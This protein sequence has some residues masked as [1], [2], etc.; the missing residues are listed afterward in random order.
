MN[1]QGEQRDQPAPPLQQ[2]QPP[3][4][5]PRGIFQPTFTRFLKKEPDPPEQ[6]VMPMAAKVRRVAAALRR[7][8]RMAALSECSARALSRSWFCLRM[9]GLCGR[10]SSLSTRLLGHSTSLG[11][12]EQFGVG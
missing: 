3:S 9:R 7:A 11:L 8:M 12:Q 6:A 10:T 4:P 2:R 5:P 1:R